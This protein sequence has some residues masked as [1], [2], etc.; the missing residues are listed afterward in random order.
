[1]VTQRRQPPS[2]GIGF[3][4]ITTCLGTGDTVVTDAGVYAPQHDSQLLIDALTLCML[5]GGRRVLDLCTGSGVV[6]IAAAH[7][8]AA[9]VTAFDTCPRA[10][11]CSR[12][13]ARRA[14]VDVDVRRG[15]VAAAVA[16]G[17][18]DLVVTNPP[19]VPV[20]SDFHTEIIPAGVGPASAWNAGGDGRRVLDPLCESAP[21]LLVR[22]GTMLLVQSEFSGVEMSL[23]AFRSAGMEAEIVLWQSIPFGPVL[24]ARAGWLER[25]GRLHAGRREEELVVIRADKR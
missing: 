23:T 1:M 8:G 14:G 12:V 17:P 21:R 13:N 18:Y 7:L 9:A 3:T 10:V 19:Y 6:A 5:S 24:S 4:L 2:K 16:S 25:I 15:S 20:G 11:R 22:G